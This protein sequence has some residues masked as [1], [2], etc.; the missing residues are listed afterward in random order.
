MKILFVCLGNICRSPLAMGTLNQ[1][2]QKLGLNWQIDAAGLANKY[3]GCPADSRVI[4]VANRHGVDL[5]YH[6]ARKFKI[7][8]FDQYDMIITM[9]DELEK[10]LRA[11]ALTLAQ[12]DK[13]FLLTD[14]L[15]GL[16]ENIDMPDPYFWDISLFESLFVKMEEACR[17]IIATYNTPNILELFEHT[18]NINALE[19]SKRA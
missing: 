10:R 13:L 16:A 3:I 18:V 2:A 4:E 8:D 15:E 6:I 14:F 17:L 1:Q 7:V 9:D 19:L 5:S 12:T 11:K